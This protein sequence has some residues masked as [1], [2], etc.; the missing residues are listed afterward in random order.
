MDES[1]GPAMTEPGTL[2][3]SLQFGDSFFPGGGTAFSW[4][5]ET[6]AADGAVAS[7]A[8]L[9]RLIAGQL[10][11]RW[12]SCD[13]PALAAAHAA[14][15]DLDAVLALDRRLEAMALARELREGSRR[16]GAALLAVHEK[17]GTPGAGAYRRLVR[18]RRAPGHLAVAQG[19][20][21][22]GAGLAEPMASALAAHSLCVGLL[23]AA[24][25]LGIAGP[26]E[27]QRILAALR[28]LVARLV[29]QPP[30]VG[31]ISAFTPQAEV[32]AM[33]HETAATRLFA[34]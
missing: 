6:L 26:I 20:V 11:H 21:W 7:A 34:N 16:A 17:L 8:D 30:P 28:P 29:A 13:R 15:G 10:T 19:L 31:R 2:L 5:L 9:E 18:S 3:A 23:G 14:C 12:A 22:R 1:G 27:A 4:G 24:V 25:R 33:R 32:A